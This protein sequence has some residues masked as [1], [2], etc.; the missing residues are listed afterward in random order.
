MGTSNDSD[1]FM[2]DAVQQIRLRKCTM[3][4]VLQRLGVSSH[5]LYR[6]AAAKNSGGSTLRASSSFLI[7]KTPTLEVPCHRPRP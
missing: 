2:Q 7:L 3:W 1:A 5:S 6:L 4:E